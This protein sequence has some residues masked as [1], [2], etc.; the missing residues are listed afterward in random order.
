MR[1]HI[2]IGPGDPV[3]PFMPASPATPY[4]KKKQQHDFT[5]T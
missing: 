1:Y 4:A 5:L 3:A 2:T